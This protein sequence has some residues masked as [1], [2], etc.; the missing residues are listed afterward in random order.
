MKQ[1][2]GTIE[3]QALEVFCV[4]KMRECY[5]TIDRIMKTIP[6]DFPKSGKT[7]K[8][9]YELINRYEGQIKGY[10]EIICWARENK[11]I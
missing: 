10:R 11:K 8:D 2:R 1:N 3:F 5:L 9:S 6:G 7:I 4:D